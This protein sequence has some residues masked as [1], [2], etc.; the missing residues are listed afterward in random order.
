MANLT[1]DEISILHLLISEHKYTIYKK[2]TTHQPNFR[3]DLASAM[4]TLEAKCLLLSNDNRRN[5][6]TSINTLFDVVKRLIATNK[7]NNN[8]VLTKNK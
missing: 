3:M 7:K 8:G 6:R 2:C 5:G 1:K 4:E